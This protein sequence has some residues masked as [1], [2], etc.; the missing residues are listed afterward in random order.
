MVLLNWGMLVFLPWWK[1]IVSSFLPYLPFSGG[2]VTPL[3]LSRITAS[4]APMCPMQVSCFV[5]FGAPWL[6]SLSINAEPCAICSFRLAVPFPLTQ[7]ACASFSKVVAQKRCNQQVVCFSGCFTEPLS[8][9]NRVPDARPPFFTPW[10]RRRWKSSLMAF[11]HWEG[12]R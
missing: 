4:K 7:Q 1:I 8:G 2:I 11:P 6:E 9:S 10:E 5:I 3:N 12:Q